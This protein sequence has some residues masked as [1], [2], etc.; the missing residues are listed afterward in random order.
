[1]TIRVISVRGT[2][3]SRVREGSRQRDVRSAFRSKG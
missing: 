1:V 3:S 2:Q